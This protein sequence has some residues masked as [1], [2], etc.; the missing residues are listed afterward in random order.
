MHASLL[1]LQL[2]L[3]TKFQ[4]SKIYNSALQEDAFVREAITCLVDNGSISE[5]HQVPF[6]TYPVSILLDLREVNKHIW[7]QSVKY[8]DLRTALLYVNKNSWCFKFDIT[9]AYHH[10]DIFQDHI[11]VLGFSWNFD[12]V[13]RY[14]QFNVLPFGL[15]SAPYIFT[16]LT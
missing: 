12:G 2:I 8:D 13:V 7:K 16:M 6:V 3:A 4:F 11:K 1:L 10:I 5:Q 15:T 14:Y 9:R